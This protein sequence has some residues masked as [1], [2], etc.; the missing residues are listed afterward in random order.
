MSDVSMYERV[1]GPAFKQLAEPVQAFHRT[2]GRRE[3]HG[4]VQTAAPASF[5]ARLLARCLGTP[6]QPSSGPIRFE[7]DVQDACEEWVRHFPTNTMRSRMAL[8]DGELTERLGLT[9]LR[10]GLEADRDRLVMRL[11]GLRFLGI[12]CPRW[13]LPRVV[14]EEEGRD[15]RLYFRVSAALPLVGQVAGYTGHLLIHAEAPA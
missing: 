14:A 6:L 9:L 7:L 5:A 8:K 3:L 10:F 11:L 1:M 12:P 13:A 4:W 2:R 15:G